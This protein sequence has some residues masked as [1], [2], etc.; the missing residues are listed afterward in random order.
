M[1]PVRYELGSYIPEDGIVHSRRHGNL[2]SN[3]LYIDSSSILV[4][5]VAE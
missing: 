5:P 1:S 2:K 3:K 4:E